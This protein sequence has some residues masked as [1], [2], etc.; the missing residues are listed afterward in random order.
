MLLAMA[1]FVA[2]LWQVTLTLYNKWL[3]SVYDFHFPLLTTTFHFA[4]KMPIARLVMWALGVAPLPWTSRIGI[5]LRI[6]PT[7]A[8]TSLDV[9]LSNLSFL[10]SRP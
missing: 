8:A 3:F 7:G 9:A 6:V 4:I 1:S 2:P 5:W 10:V